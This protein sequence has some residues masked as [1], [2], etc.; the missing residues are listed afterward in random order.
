MPQTLRFRGWRLGFPFHRKQTEFCDAAKAKETFPHA[1][2]RNLVT[3]S[4]KFRYIGW[5]EKKEGGEKLRF[6]WYHDS[7]STEFTVIAH[8]IASDYE[9]DILLGRKLP[10][11]HIPIL[12]Q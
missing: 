10:P 3:C 6:D 11:W 12:K 2:D 5:R 1:Y 7:G 4:I 9:S 8:R